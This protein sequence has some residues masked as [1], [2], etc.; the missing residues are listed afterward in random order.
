MIGRAGLATM[1]PKI[2]RIHVALASK[3][4]EHLQVGVHIVDVVDVR[5]ILV[6]CPVLGQWCFQVERL[7]F[8]FRLVI[9]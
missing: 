2:E 8:R 7:A 3:V 5:R 4:V 1:W 9:H 6:R